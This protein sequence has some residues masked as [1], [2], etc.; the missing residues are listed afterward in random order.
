M[1]IINKT[2]QHIYV[3]DIG[4]VI[5]LPK[6]GIVSVPLK[7]VVKSSQLMDLMSGGLVGFEEEDG[8]LSMCGSVEIDGVTRYIVGGSV[9]WPGDGKTKPVIEDRALAAT[10]PIKVV[11]RERSKEIGTNRYVV[12]KS[13]ECNICFDSIGKVLN[14]QNCCVILTNEEFE[15]KDVQDALSSGLIMVDRVLRCEIDES[16]AERLVQVENSE[17]SEQLEDLSVNPSSPYVGMGIQCM[18][19]GPL[20][21][22]GG[23][24]N[25]NRQYIMGLTR[26]GVAVR[27]TMMKTSDQVEIPMM[28][29][30]EIIAKTPVREDCPKVYSTN[31]PRSHVGDSIAYT[32]METDVK[33]HPLLVK[34]MEVADEIWVPSEW[35]RQTFENGGVKK[36]I[37]VMPLGINH[38]I[39]KPQK[40]PLM[41][42]FGLKRFVFL[43]VS[44]WMWRKGWDVL[45]KAYRR[46][47]SADDDVSL[48][49]F[50]RVPLWGGTHTEKINIDIRE[51]FGNDYSGF[52]HLVVVPAVLP[53]N[54]MPFLYNSADAFSLF[55]RG[56]GWGLPYCEATA[57][58]LPVIGSDHG[59]Q[60]MFL[61]DS[62][63]FIV[64]PDASA[65]CHP[66]MMKISPFYHDMLFADF[67][68]KAIDEAAEKM[69]YVYEHHD[70]AKSRAALC[71]K[72]LLENFTW[73][74]A[75]ERVAARLGEMK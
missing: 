11:M 41:F 47:F 45:L 57:S 39:Y 59:G 4:V 73:E 8:D 7:T 56:E 43:G 27:P 37:K 38:H 18:W 55:S 50:S 21:D 65:P 75:S 20:F 5:P 62:N 70:E 68:E 66:Y 71:R 49:I 23:Y 13:V 46:A 30:L 15:S 72:N 25:M 1:R 63:S 34:H 22:A 51:M 9:I 35:N 32:M 53:T 44:T 28:K 40:S 69:R 17:C 16:G 33:V 60:Q 29:T 31:I 74:L 48:M 64:K 14:Q 12:R 54:M 19:E 2:E 10:D 67:T 52:P 58:G 6:Y 42:R 24:A 3:N 36:R 26:L 61:N